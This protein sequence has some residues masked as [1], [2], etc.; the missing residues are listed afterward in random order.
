MHCS[1]V[2]YLCARGP[3]TK[4]NPAEEGI[5]AP[6]TVAKKGFSNMNQQA[7]NKRK[8]P[9]VAVILWV[10]VAL[11][12]VVLG[13]SLLDTVGIYGM[14]KAGKSQSIRLTENHVD[15][16]R[17]HVAQNQLYYQYQYVQYGMMQD[18]TGG[19]ISALNW[20]VTDFISYMIPLT[21]GSGDYDELAYDYAEQYLTYCEGAKEAEL[22]DDFLAEVK[23]DIDEYVQGLK[24]MAKAGNTTFGGFL[25]DYM[26]NG[27][28]EK[29]VRVA[30]E[31]YYIGAKYAE[32]LT[33]E[34]AGKVE[35]ADKT[36]YLNNHKSDF[37]TSTYSSY[38]LVNNDMA[39]AMENCK[40]IDDVK[41]VIVDYYMDTM[42]KFED[43]YKSKILDKNIAD[44]PS[45]E[46]TKADVR[47]TLLA[48]LGIGENE[49]VF[50][51]TDTDTYKKA[52]YDVV[53]A[54][55]TL[56]SA[57]ANLIKESASAPWVDTAPKKDDGSADEEASKALTDFQKWIFADERKAGDYK[58][59]KTEKTTTGSDGSSTTKTTYTWYLVEE[60]MVLDEEHTKNAHYI[61]LTDDGEDVK[62]NKKTGEQKAKE[63]HAALAAVEQDPDKRSAAFKEWMEKN[64]P[65][66]SS[67]L[68]EYISY[69]DMESSYKDLADWLYHKDRAGKE[70]ELV[71]EPIKIMDTKDVKKVAGYIVAIYMGENEETWKVDATQAIAAE[72]LTEWYEKA[73]VD[74]GVKMDYEAPE[75]E[76]E[77]TATK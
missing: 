72:K 9:Y 12:V 38:A 41:T 3:N 61:L 74:Y 22:Y 56:A 71:A 66:Y 52:A 15:V 36:E 40:T 33:D 57:Q 50:K 8:F 30:M 4:N 29:D 58:L 43:N 14:T 73:V 42:K 49:A 45:K 11:V 27:V 32:K 37:Y 55:K 51:S 18:P 7:K 59:I 25:K 16:Y 2:G 53:K 24:D 20:T 34:Y 54:I 28:S 65:G 26:G 44:I 31:Y 69:E 17:Y 10:T 63:L 39:E 6:D 76:A 35:D 19:L 68:V 5:S 48:E 62:E 70:G 60:T 75:T 1:I 21:V 64:A 77:T 47:T 13:H 23:P 46:Q 67:E